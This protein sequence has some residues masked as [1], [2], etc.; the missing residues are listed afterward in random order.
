MALGTST[1][2][3]MT[4]VETS[5]STSPA[6]NACITR[7]L[8]SG[9]IRPCSISTRSPLERPGREL[10]GEVLDRVQ[11]AGVVA[12]HRAVGELD[13]VDPR[14]DDVG[15]P[16]L[17]DLLADPLPRAFEPGRLRLGGYDGRLHVAAAGGELAQGRGVEVAEDSHRHGPRDRRRRHHQHVR[18]LPGLAAERRPLLHAEA[19]LLVD[20]DQTEV[21]ELHVLLEQRVRADHDPGL[22]AGSLGER[23]TPGRRVQRPGQQ[24]HPGR[25][26]GAAEE[27]ALGEVAEHRHDRAVVLLGEHLGRR[28]QRRLAAR[29]DDLEH[30]AQRDHRLAR[31]DLALEQPVHRVAL[32]R[33]RRRSPRP[34]RAGRR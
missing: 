13:R 30:R 27:A 12:L 19:V 26:L 14:A 6:A 28:Q 34:R 20:D 7:S 25:L 31:A 16:A 15:L 17:G 8:S 23:R 1:P 10:R 22:A 32:D 29:V 24:R 33:A 18:R 4:V 3:S 11:R 2:T 5:T 21:G 9:A